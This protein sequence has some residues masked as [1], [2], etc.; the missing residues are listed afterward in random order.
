MSLA[1]LRK[2]AK[3]WLDEL[4]AGDA[5]ARVR[6]E[7]AYPD[8]PPRPVLRD[9]QH[10]L[11]REHGYD[12]WLG[13]KQAVDTSR[14][15][16]GVTAP[17]LRTAAEYEQVANDMVTAFEAKDDGALHR[18][19]AHYQRSF[20]HDDLWAEV[21]RRVYAFRQR[22]SRVPKNYLQLTEAQLVVAQD[23]GFGSWAALL[24]ALETGA[25]P[26]APHDVDP[27]ESRIAP[28][29]MLS[30]RE[31]DELIA[32]MKEHGITRLDANGMMTDAVLKRVAALDHVTVLSLGGSRELTDD[33]LLQLARMPQLEALDLSEY[34]GGRLT[35]RGLE[36]LRHLPNLRS[37]EMTWQRGITDAGIAN[38]KYC[39][40]VE[41]VNLMGSP[42]GNGAIETLQ[43]KAALRHF[44]SGR[45]VTDPGLPLLHNFPRL[46]T[47]H[48][49]PIPDEPD[50]NAER[51]AHLLID[52]PFTNAGLGQLAGLEGVLELDLFWHVTGITSEGFAHLAGLPNLASLGADGALSDDAA[53]G[54][55]ARIPQLRRLRAQGLVAT[56]AG[57]EALAQSATLQFLWTGKDTIKLTSRGF[58]ALS[59]MPKLRG[60]GVSCKLVGDG[61]LARFPA[62]PSLREL[63]PIDVQD[64]GFPHIGRC[65][66]LERL[67]CMYCRDTS[68][69]ATEHITGLPL[70]YYYAGLTQIT[71]RSL[72]LLGRITPLEQV[73]F[74]ECQKITDAGLPFLTRLPKLREVALDSLPGVTL[75][76]TKVFPPHVRVRYST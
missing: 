52:G 24:R 59:R 32:I 31:W 43:G 18:V 56:D 12:N 47:W 33:G 65:E 76:G 42:T 13:L 36:V 40:R 68:D 23:A 61:A 28:R 72:E 9:V 54:H 73:E 2:E 20:T 1:N 75:E 60:L 26:V 55:F 6:L 27:A 11:A 63:T 14:G 15:A 16:V 74:Y 38:L 8:A 50:G 57:F 41:R 22:S 66:R 34:P 3:R 44:S 67:T 17:S 37:F 45:M 30:D 48:G 70:K 5:D 64:A 4:R 46:K 71:D 51:G 35:D 53:L 7:R 25:P 21:W 58:I 69:A 62:F 19:N 10:A 29:R 49:S 39:D